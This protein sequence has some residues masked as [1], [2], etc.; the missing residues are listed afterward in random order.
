MRPARASTSPIERGT[1]QLTIDGASHML[2]A[3]DSIYYAGDC[4]HAFANPGREPCVYYLAM[5][6]RRR[7][8]RT[9][10]EAGCRRSARG[11]RS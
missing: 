2:A 7:A 5:D 3:G 9:P 1:L 11:G 4:R 8:A 10:G 6:A